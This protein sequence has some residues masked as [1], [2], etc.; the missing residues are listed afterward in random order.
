MRAAPMSFGLVQG[1][2]RGGSPGQPCRNPARQKVNRVAL[3]PKS[4]FNSCG[5]GLYCFTDSLTQAVL[6]CPVLSSSQK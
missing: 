4:E 6:L 1:P 5:D 3:G 2:M